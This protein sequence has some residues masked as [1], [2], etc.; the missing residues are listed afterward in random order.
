LPPEHARALLPARL[1]L[2]GL[3][4]KEPFR[5]LNGFLS[6]PTPPPDDTRKRKQPRDPPES[7]AHRKEETDSENLGTG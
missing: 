6:F 2:G 1:T 3:L 4:L 7:T 5:A